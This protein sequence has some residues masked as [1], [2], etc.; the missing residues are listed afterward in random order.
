MRFPY[1]ST[2]AEM[3]S[4]L[5]NTKAW[6]MTSLL[7]SIL[8]KNVKVPQKFILNFLSQSWCGSSETELC[9]FRKIIITRLTYLSLSAVR[10]NSFQNSLTYKLRGLCVTFYTKNVLSLSVSSWP[11]KNHKIQFLLLMK[12]LGHIHMSSFP[13]KRA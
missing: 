2:T 1:R 6:K 9:C 10:H 7:S 12:L 11:P 4:P 8:D 5:C 3:I 13:S